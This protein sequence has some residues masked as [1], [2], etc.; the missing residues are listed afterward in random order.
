MENLTWRRK[1]WT[2]MGMGVSINPA[3]QIVGCATIFAG[4]MGKLETCA[5]ESDST[6]LTAAT[7][8]LAVVFWFLALGSGFVYSPSSKSSS[9]AYIPILG[10]L[11]Q[12]QVNDEA[13]LSVPTSLWCDPHGAFGAL[14]PVSSSISSRTAAAT[15]TA[16]T[17][18]TRT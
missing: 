16:A 11:S 7:H 14:A 12:I 1:K 5:F 17:F 9:M 15:T 8:I 10:V 13:A 6:I 4:Y 18:H 3:H 2:M